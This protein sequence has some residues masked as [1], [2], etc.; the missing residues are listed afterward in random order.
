MEKT[1]REIR[2]GLIMQWYEKKLN[3]DELFKV[4][5]WNRIIDEKSKKN[6]KSEIISEFYENFNKEKE[7]QEYKDAEDLYKG[8]RS[9]K[10]EIK[11]KTEEI[12]ELKKRNEQGLKEIDA[13]FFEIA[14]NVMSLDDGWLLKRIKLKRED[15]KRDELQRQQREINKEI[16]RLQAEKE[17]MVAKLK[18][19]E[20]EYWPKIKRPKIEWKKISYNRVWQEKKEEMTFKK[21]KERYVEMLKAKEEYMA[22]FMAEVEKMDLGISEKKKKDTVELLRKSIKEEIEL[23]KQWDDIT[24]LADETEKWIEENW[25]SSIKKIIELEE[26][27]VEKEREIEEIVA[28]WEWAKASDVLQIREEEFAKKK[29]LLDLQDKHK[30]IKAEFE[31]KLKDYDGSIIDWETDKLFKTREERKNWKKREETNER[32]WI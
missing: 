30:A 22:K 17:A 9:A 23:M 26:E 20:E 8:I 5:E 16:Y 25:E 6:L 18:E 28:K 21:Y 1:P 13:E 14:K 4:L 10:G 7:G 27:M 12:K 29:E 19:D 11:R 3:R 31:W 24:K 2:E 32:N 15:E